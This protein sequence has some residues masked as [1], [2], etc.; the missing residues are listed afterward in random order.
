MIYVNFRRTVL[1]YMGTYYSDNLQHMTINAYTLFNI[2]IDY[3]QHALH[4]WIGKLINIIWCL[5]IYFCLV[6]YLLTIYYLSI[7]FNGSITIEKSCLFNHNDI[8]SLATEGCGLTKIQRSND[9][10]T[11]DRG[12]VEREA[13]W[14]GRVGGR[15]RRGEGEPCLRQ[16]YLKF[17]L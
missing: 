11:A 17:K 14:F 10:F 8:L 12:L 4:S 15:V 5:I 3:R 1:D 13:G 7:E 16:H 6:N 9:L 2:L